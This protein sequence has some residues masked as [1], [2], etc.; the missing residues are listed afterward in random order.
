VTEGYEV[1]YHIVWV[2]YNSRVSEKSSRYGGNSGVN[3]AV[4]M[5]AEEILTVTSLINEKGEEFQ[6]PAYIIIAR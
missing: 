2:T 4:A 3:P 5:D 1:I 6:Q